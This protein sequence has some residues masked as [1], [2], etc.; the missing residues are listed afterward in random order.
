MVAA[1]RGTKSVYQYLTALGVVGEAA[2]RIPW[3]MEIET[4]S[5]DAAART[6]ASA[7]HAH[8]DRLC[9]AAEF[10]VVERC[11]YLSIC[12][13]TALS[14]RVRAA[15]DEFLDH[16]MYWRE[17]RAVREVR[18]EGARDKFRPTRR[19]GPGRH[20]DHQ[21][22]VRGNQRDRHGD[23]V[24]S[25][26]QR[27]PVHRTRAPEQRPAVAA[28]APA[29]RRDA[30]GRAGRR[31]HFEPEADRRGHRRADAR[32][33]L[34]LRHLFARLAHRSRHDRPRLPRARCPVPRRCC[35]VGGNPSDSTSPTTPSMPWW[36]RPPRVCSDSTAADSST[37]GSDWA[38]AWCRRTCRAR[39]SNCRRS[40][41]RRCAA[42]RRHP[43]DAR[44]FEVGAV[45]YAA[46]YAVDASLALLSEI[47]AP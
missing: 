33:L 19:C 45:D 37:A 28:S 7:P 29:R 39:Q 9:D 23:P 32:R 47:G 17:T 35:P 34:L 10:P 1:R 44:R 3:R 20:R 13:S 16:V 18:V 15:V 14:R 12:D 8:R 38:H 6:L 31:R 46:C 30:D 36:R 5:L 24:A 11:T 40:A 2:P 43:A 4:T 27:R 42:R 21:E 22:R 25:R 26:R 41:I